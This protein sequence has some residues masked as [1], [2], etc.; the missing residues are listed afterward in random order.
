MM[1]S[2]PIA[3]M[4]NNMLNWM[5]ACGYRMCSLGASSGHLKFAP[6]SSA[7]LWAYRTPREAS[8]MASLTG[9][10]LLEQV[11]DVRYYDVCSQNTRT[12]NLVGAGRNMTSDSDS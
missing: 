2:L 3:T 5:A 12:V 8:W 7:Y 6:R 10:G 11:V 1:V 4:S 9:A